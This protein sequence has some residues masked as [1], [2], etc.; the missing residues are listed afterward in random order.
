MPR[1]KNE[2]IKKRMRKTL[3]ILKI[4][5]GLERV[6]KMKKS[7]I[8]RYHKPTQTQHVLASFSHSSSI[9]QKALI[10]YAKV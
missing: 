7:D 2:E 9:A 6:E 3:K 5:Y 1:R 4:M 8:I 10:E